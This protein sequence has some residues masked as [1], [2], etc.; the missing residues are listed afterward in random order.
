MAYFELRYRRLGAG[1]ECVCQPAFAAVLTVLVERHLKVKCVN[2]RAL[3]GGIYTYEDTSSTGR[4][5]AFATKTLDLA[6][7]LNLV[8]LQDGHLDFL[9]LMLDLLRSL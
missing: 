9:A 8:V 2:R 4:G 7:G 6:I 3:R 1:L 5:R